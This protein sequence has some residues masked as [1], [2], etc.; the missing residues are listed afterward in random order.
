MELEGLRGLAAIAVALYH[1]I[2]LMYPTL[3]D[4]DAR[5]AHTPIE[6]AIYGTPITL[7]F[8]GTLAVAIFF[9]LSGFVLSIGFFQ[10]GD[11]AIVKKL[12][13]GRYLR[14]M[15][16]ALASVL[17]AFILIS[18]NSSELTKAAG[19]ITGSSAY[20]HKWS[21]D[22]N[23]FEALKI[24]TYDI[25]I[26]DK[27]VPV[28]HVLW[29]MHTEFFGSFLVFGFLLL[30]AK[31]RYRLLAYLIL[32][33]GTFGTWF[34]AFVIGMAIADAYNNKLLEKLKHPLILLIFAAGAIFL[35]S[36][37]KR[38]GDSVYEYLEFPFIDIH[39]RIF[40]I[41]IAAALF[42]LVVLLSARVK[43]FLQKPFLSMLG[44]Y[45]F[46]LY[47]T[48]LLVI[49]T[50][51]AALIITL[52]EPLGFSLATVVTFIITVLVQIPVTYY[53][54]RYIDMPSIHFAKNVGRI[55]RENL[56]IDWNGMGMTLKKHSYTAYD[57]VKRG[58][59]GD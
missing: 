59:I 34:L 14:L 6:S 5:L 13:T 51:S 36:Y 26:Y 45:T 27:S 43:T 39:Y 40:Y 37:P 55:Y 2:V 15:L 25:F 38:S 50:V 49:Y 29:T 56:P 35:G 20:A 1:F 46:S 7:L 42:I 4:G 19:A 18:L 58:L 52:S 11:E 24:G 23:I 22:L 48:H 41:T 53:F 33:I 9:V 12:A 30:F 10:T 8:A 44:K 32:A 57:F 54:E 31:S 21:F 47:L 16:P 28:N 3:R 17:L